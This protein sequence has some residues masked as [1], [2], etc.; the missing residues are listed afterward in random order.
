MQVGS[1]VRTL[2]HIAKLAYVTPSRGLWVIGHA[3]CMCSS[4]AGA[5]YL[6]YLIVD[7]GELTGPEYV[8]SEW[9][10]AIYTFRTAATLFIV[11]TG[12]LQVWVRR[13]DL[14]CC[15]ASAYIFQVR[16]IAYLIQ[17]IYILKYLPRRLFAI[18]VT[19]RVRAV[20]IPPVAGAPPRT[21][22]DEHHHLHAGAA[23]VPGPLHRHRRAAH[24][25]DRRV[26]RVQ[27][28]D[29]GVGMGSS[30]LRLLQR[31]RALEERSGRTIEIVLPVVR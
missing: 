22:Y 5:I 24:A 15:I 30:L 23:A 11:P 17:C 27:V 13:R 19:H 25:G 3:I 28:G 21:A 14:I 7:S 9:N 29:G 2:W 31:T 12:L 1:G 4:F 26:L 6:L 8:T 10:R 20:W 18:G 16:L